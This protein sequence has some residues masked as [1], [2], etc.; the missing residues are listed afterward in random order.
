MGEGDCGEQDRNGRRQ[1]LIQC[2]LQAGEGSGRS[3]HLGCK[4]SVA[5]RAGAQWDLLVILTSCCCPRQLFPISL[6]PF[7]Y[8]AQHERRQ[9][10]REFHSAFQAVKITKACHL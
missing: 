8:D 2:I 1:F 9:H 4:S 5:H 10:T 7:Q 3:V 6:C